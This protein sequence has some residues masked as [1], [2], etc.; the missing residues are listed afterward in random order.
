MKRKLAAWMPENS[1]AA[2]RLASRPQVELLQAGP[3]QVRP[4]DPNCCVLQKPHGG[5]SG[6]GAMM[7]ASAGGFN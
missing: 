3:R 7:A 6:S 5:H 2:N 1:D 4:A